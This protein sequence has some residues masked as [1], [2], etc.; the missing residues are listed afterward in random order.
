MKPTLTPPEQAPQL[1]VRVAPVRSPDS[2]SMLVLP[3]VWSRMKMTPKAD[4]N[5]RVTMQTSLF[6]RRGGARKPLS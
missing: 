3:D 2:A 6:R 1:V 4:A 5:T